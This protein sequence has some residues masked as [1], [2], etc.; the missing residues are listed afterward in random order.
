MDPPTIH[1]PK[2]DAGEG[3]REGAQDEDSEGG[4]LFHTQQ[5]C[6]KTPGI[7][8][9]PWLLS[10][11]RE[12]AAPPPPRLKRVHVQ[13]QVRWGRTGGERRKPSSRF[14][15]AV[16][17]CT[18]HVKGSVCPDKYNRQFLC[19]QKAVAP[20]PPPHGKVCLG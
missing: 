4:T 17:V 19:S 2:R 20:P 9:F 8:H 1:Y 12:E 13:H 3:L 7:H 5:L 16:C 11:D 18:V 15:K 14:E 10:A 6:I